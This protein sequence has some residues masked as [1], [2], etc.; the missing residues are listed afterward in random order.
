[1]PCVG[2]Y[3]P[4]YEQVDTRSQ[5]NSFSKDERP[6]RIRGQVVHFL[7]HLAAQPKNKEVSNNPES[8]VQENR[9]KTEQPK[10]IKNGRSRQGSSLLKSGFTFGADNQSFLKTGEAHLTFGGKRYSES[11]LGHHQ[12]RSV[13]GRI[14][15]I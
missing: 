3:K 13:F 10:E 9:E 6:P 1:M 7:G 8:Q 11:R 12:S 15:F 5:V 14:Y 4:K 2:H